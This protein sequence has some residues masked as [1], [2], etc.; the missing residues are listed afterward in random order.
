MARTLTLEPFESRLIDH[1]ASFSPWHASSLSDAQLRRAVRSGIDRAEAHGIT[2]TDAVRFYVEMTVIFGSSFDTDPLV[3]WAG[4]ILRDPA[5]RDEMPRVLRLHDA[6]L[7]YRHAVNGGGGSTTAETLRKLLELAGSSV[8][9]ANLRVET[10]ALETMRWLNP[11]FCA[12]VGEPAL[13]EMRSRGPELASQLGVATDEGILLVEALMF[14]LG[15]GFAADPFHPWVA[16]S[17]DAA[18]AAPGARVARLA[19]EARTRLAHAVH[20]LGAA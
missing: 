18:G 5:S 8:S 10:T 7:A 12:Y 1:L 9:I 16:T 6:L 15:H 13:R 2:K 4:Q 14:V 3:P 20:F 17:L 19:G 11:S